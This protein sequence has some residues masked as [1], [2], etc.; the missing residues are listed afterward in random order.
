METTPTYIAIPGNLQIK[1]YRL[2]NPGWRYVKVRQK[3]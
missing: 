3:I 2:L 1:K